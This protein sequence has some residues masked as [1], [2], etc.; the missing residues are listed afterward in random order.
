MC[1][2]QRW[3]NSAGRNALGPM[4]PLRTHL[5]KG[6]TAHQGRGV[7]NSPGGHE[8]VH[9]CHVPEPAQQAQ[10]THA[11]WRCALETPED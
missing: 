9:G 2:F 1:C 10:E 8:H 7:E 5:P 11:S 6:C 4:T 3:A